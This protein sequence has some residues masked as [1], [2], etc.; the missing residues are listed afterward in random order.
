MDTISLNNLSEKAGEIINESGY[1]SIIATHKLL[2]SR[3]ENPQSYSA[4]IFET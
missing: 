3:I 2:H 4:I 1:D